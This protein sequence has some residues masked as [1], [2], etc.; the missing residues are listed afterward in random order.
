M[1]FNFINLLC[2]DFLILN[3]K[4]EKASQ[5]TADNVFNNQN[6]IQQTSSPKDNI[7]NS[8]DA[9]INNFIPIQ[10]MFQPLT[11]F[12]NFPFD[13]KNF[14]NYQMMNN[15]N[16]TSQYLNSLQTNMANA[17]QNYLTRRIF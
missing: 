15:W 9:N 1:S 3:R 12:P 4:T 16:F 2:I 6:E 7:Q 8:S 11:Q 5:K 17:Y 13:W 14:A 10:Q